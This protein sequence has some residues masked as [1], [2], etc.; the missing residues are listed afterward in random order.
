MEPNLPAPMMPTRMGPDS[1][2]RFWSNVAKFMGNNFLQVS[3]EDQVRIKKCI[4][5]KSMINAF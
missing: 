1:A 5:K 2:V 3:M 4:F